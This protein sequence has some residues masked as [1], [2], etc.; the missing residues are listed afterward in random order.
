MRTIKAEWMPYAEEI[1]EKLGI[2]YRKAETGSGYEVDV[3]DDA[4]QWITED[5]AAFLEQVQT[6]SPLPVVTWRTAND[7]ERLKKLNL[8]GEPCTIC[9]ADEDKIKQIYGGGQ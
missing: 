6:D 4:W 2:P 8:F 3:S 7:A 1:M 9:L 5:A